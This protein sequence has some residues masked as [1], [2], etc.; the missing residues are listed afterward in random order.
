M[1][2]PLRSFSSLPP[3][4]FGVLAAGLTLTAA[5]ANA[6]SATFTNGDGN[7]AY[8]DALNW[9]TLAVPN[10]NSGDT[11]TIANGSAVTY[12]PGGDLTITNGGMLQIT[13]GSFTQVT[14]NNYIQ[15]GTGG[16]TN[17]GTILVNGGTFN[18]GTAS[19]NPFNVNGTG[20]TFSVTSGTAN[21]TSSFNMP[22]GLTFSQS[23]GTVN[24]TGNETDFNSPTN[25]LGGG[26]FNTTL[27][28]GVN[29]AA[30][31]RFNIS[32]GTLNLTG[33][34]AIYGGG[35]TQ[36]INFTLNSTGQ[37]TFT[38]GTFTVAS[39]KGFLNSG[40]IEYNGTIE[41]AASGY[42][43][44]NFAQNGNN[45][46]LSLNAVPEPSTVALTALGAAGLMGWTLRRRNRLA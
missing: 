18:Q 45:V 5:S 17:G 38:S 4:L 11:A 19:S 34:T 30:G 22:L 35:S 15:L 12:T 21:I 13:N 36:Y 32:G 42:S 33:S 40:A 37:I 7:G 39:V 43:D 28:T 24:V 23:G 25:T 3:R 27:I 9:S 1:K 26:L 20:N 8:T 41:N 6:A 10:T 2:L 44:F 46:T 14:G 31:D 16:G 29:G